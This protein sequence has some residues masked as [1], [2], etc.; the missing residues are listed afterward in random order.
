MSQI[1]SN[2][3]GIEVS[4]SGLHPLSHLSLELYISL[5]TMHFIILK[6]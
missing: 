3:V 1:L 2:Y 6:K 5:G 4:Q